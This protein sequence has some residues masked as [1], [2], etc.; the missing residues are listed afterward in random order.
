MSVSWSANTGPMTAAVFLIAAPSP[1][2]T[3]I[4][5]A[6]ARAD[7]RTGRLIRAIREYARGDLAASYTILLRPSRERASAS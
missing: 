4:V 5:A 1:R 3:G 2:F 7:R 6:P